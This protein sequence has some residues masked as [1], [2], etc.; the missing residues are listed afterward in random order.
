MKSAELFY[1]ETLE[2]IFEENNFNVPELD[3]IN[4]LKKFADKSKNFIDI[5]A[6]IGTYSCSLAKSFNEVH[7]FE[8]C[9]MHYHYLCANLVKHCSFG[10]SFTYPLALSHENTRSTF[11]LREQVGGTNGLT[12]K[13]DNGEDILG[14]NLGSYLVDVKTLD[15]FDLTNVGLIK[16]DVEGYE[17]SVLEG[18]VKTLKANNFP[19]IVFELNA[20]ITHNPNHS[21]QNDPSSA[22]NSIFNFL[23]NLGY[24]I[25]TLKSELSKFDGESKTMLA[26]KDNSLNSLLYRYIQRPDDE[27]NKFWLGCA[28]QN[29]GHHS[30]G[31]GYFLSIA[32]H[33]EDE[34]LAYECLLKKAQGFAEMGGRYA[35]FKNSCLMAISLQPK[36][37]EAYYMLCSCYST[38]TDWRDEDRWQQIYAWATVGKLASQE[39]KGRNLL[40]SIGY[41]KH[42]IFDYY[43]ALSLWWVGR[44]EDS[45]ANFHKLLDNPNLNA[46]YYSRCRQ[47]LEMIAKKELLFKT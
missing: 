29:I 46:E 31:M 42:F 38:S 17:L 2:V 24:K 12:L 41:Y 34:D 21:F 14:D 11:Y 15:S 13:Y 25:F 36:R 26:T 40:T 28:Y 6:H 8:P 47:A 27:Y 18:S 23:R 16:M 43:I 32:E 10:K 30:S 3:V 39:F 7:S 5:G 22:E 19:P 20:Y 35:H 44:F 37:P 45:A 4:Y 9:S 33:T 1:P